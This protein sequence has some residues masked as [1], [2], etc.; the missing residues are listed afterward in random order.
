MQQ[1][2]PGIRLTILTA[3]PSSTFSQ[4]GERVKEAEVAPISGS[5]LSAFYGLGRSNGKIGI[6]RFIVRMLFNLD[7]REAGSL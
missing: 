4:T 2:R 1:L 5:L 7:V 3:L 6:H